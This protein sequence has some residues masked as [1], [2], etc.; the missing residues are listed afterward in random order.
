MYVVQNK[1]I[2][3]KKFVDLKISFRGFSKFY[4]YKMFW[5]RI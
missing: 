4:A 5:R 2:A 3:Q 1:G